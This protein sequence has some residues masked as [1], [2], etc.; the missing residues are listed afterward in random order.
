MASRI[1]KIIDPNNISGVNSVYNN[2]PVPLEDLTISVQLSV[3]KKSR[4]IL[5]ADKQG[6]FSE[7]ESGVNIKFIEG[8]K[9]GN[10]KS[11]TTKFT[12]LTSKDDDNNDEALGMTSIDID[13][14]SSYAPQITIQFIDVRGSAI[15]QNEDRISKGNN[16]YS[17]FFQ[18]PYP[19]YKLS[20]KGYYGQQ[21]EYCLHMVKFNSRFNSL[22]Q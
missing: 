1:P 20:I 15:F 18:L 5:T 7:T 11:L 6:T 12:D 9:I 4:S 14:N 16:K 3:E 22:C 17:V 21:V 2:I 13:F 8:N 10:T 19:L